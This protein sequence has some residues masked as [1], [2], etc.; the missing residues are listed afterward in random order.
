MDETFKQLG[1]LLLGS[2]PTII[3]LVALY[4]VYLILVQKP[5]ARVLAERRSKTQGAIEKAQA[6]VAA[7]EA[8]TAEYEQRLREAR[9][10]M[11]QRQEARRQ[12]A[13]QIRAQAVADTRAKAQARVKQARTEIEQDKQTAQNALQ[14]E[15]A[16]LATEIIRVVLQPAGSAGGGR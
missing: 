15:S 7:A 6:D 13:L 10:A 14:G 16:R 2:I 1:E 12:Q 8:K 5:L 11:F 3:F 9:T 4:A